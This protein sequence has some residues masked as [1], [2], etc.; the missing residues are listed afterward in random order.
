MRKSAAPPVVSGDGAESVYLFTP[1]TTC[2]PASMAAMRRA[3][4]STSRS[5]M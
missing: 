3:F 5:F 2:S 4:D 1:T